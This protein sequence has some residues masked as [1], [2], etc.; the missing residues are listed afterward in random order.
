MVVG[1]R[2]VQREIDKV[3]TIGDYS[4]RGKSPMETLVEEEIVRWTRTFWSLVSSLLHRTPSFVTL[5]SF[6]LSHEY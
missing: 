1:N 3:G 5:P 6:R 4:N 2:E